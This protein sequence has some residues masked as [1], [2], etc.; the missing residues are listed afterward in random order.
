MS[1]TLASILKELKSDLKIEFFESL[2][3]VAGE[4]SDGWNNAGTGHAALCELNYTPLRDNG[5]VNISKALEI[6]E[7]F[8]VS[9]QFWAYLIGKGVIK[10]P[11]EFINQVPHM[12]F[13]RGESDCEYLRKRYDALS[14]HHLFSEMEFS[15]DAETLREWMPLVMENRIQRSASPPPAWRPART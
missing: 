10:S 9:K 14:E 12:S 1:A 3:K 2:E 6:N 8:E 15:E 11:G 13:V 5:S 4:S 7:A